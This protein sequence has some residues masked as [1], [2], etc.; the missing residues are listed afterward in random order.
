MNKV[1][2]IIKEIWKPALFLILIFSSIFILKH[3]SEKSHIKNKEKMEMYERIQDS[4]VTFKNKYG[5]SVNKISVLE[6]SN[7][8]YLLEIKTKDETMLSLIDLVKKNQ[9]EL[10]KPGSTAVVIQRETI[11]DTITKEKLV[12]TIDKDKLYFK[13]SLVNKWVSNKYERKGDSSIWNLKVKDDLSMTIK[14]DKGIK[15]A[16]ITNHSPYSNTK[17]LRMWQFNDSNT[18]KDKKWGIGIQVGYGVSLQD[19]LKLSP[20]IGVGVSKNIITF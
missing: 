17:N 10:N 14:E 19:P 18:R 7:S 5:E 6:S 3:F 12:Y 13:D 2:K 20:Y 1:A 15:Y 8:K 9:K 11:I 16:E 4:L